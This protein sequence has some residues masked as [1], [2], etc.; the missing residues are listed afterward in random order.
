MATERQLEILNT[1]VA[2]YIKTGEPVSS[3]AIL[4]N[5]EKLTLSSATIRNEMVILESEGYI[6]KLNSSSSRT[7]GRIPTNKGY[8]HYLKTVKNNPDSIISM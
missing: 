2:D 4:D 5:N 8:E 6:Y 7:S 1:I 3:N